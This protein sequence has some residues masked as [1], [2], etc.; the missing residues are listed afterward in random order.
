VLATGFKTDAFVRPMRVTGRNGADLET[1]WDLH[2]KA[3][4]AV[5]IPDFPNFFMLNGPSGPVGNFSLVDIAERQWGYI[6]KLIDLLRTGEYSSVSPKAEALEKYERKRA[7][8]AK[9]TVFASGC[10]SWYLDVEGV[11]QVWPWSYEH[12]I[13]VMAA[14]DLVDYELFG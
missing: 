5:T 1:L 9:K 13:A 14:P 12:F 6:D 7:E 3:Y 11:P 8:A 2:P 10:N 4:Y